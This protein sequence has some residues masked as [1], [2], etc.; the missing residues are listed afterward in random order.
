[1]LAYFQR[2][3]RT[4]NRDA[5]QSK[6]C[7][8]LFEEQSNRITKSTQKIALM[9]C[10]MATLRFLEEPSSTSF[11]LACSMPPKQ[12]TLANSPE[13]PHWIAPL[14]SLALDCIA[15]GTSA[16]RLSIMEF[17]GHLSQQDRFA[18]S[19][20]AA[21]LFDYDWG[22]HTRARRTAS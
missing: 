18:A 16:D 5:S 12:I 8:I 19:I 22:T 3:A 17:V 13:T 9:Q 7:N 15:R 20:L 4:K 14:Y 2:I 6:F 10:N 1:M 21:K 11:L